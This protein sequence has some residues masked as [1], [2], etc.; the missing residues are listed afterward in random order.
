LIES[1]YFMAWG[2][3]DAALGVDER[4]ALPFELEASGQVARRQRVAKL[5]HSPHFDECGCAEAPVEVVGDG[6]WA[7]GLGNVSK[8]TLAL[9]AR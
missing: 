4:N 8:S 9:P 1:A 2:L 7:D 5:E 3:E 6:H